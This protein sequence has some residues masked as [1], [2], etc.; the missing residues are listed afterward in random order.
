VLEYTV[1]EAG[2]V[3]VF[4]SNDG[5]EV[6]E[7]YFD[8]FK[9][10][11][12]KS[13]VVSSQDYY[14]FGLAFNSYSRENS[15]ANQ[16]KFQG[17]EHQDELDLGWDSFKWRN[18]QPDI[19]RFFNVDP[20]AEKYVYN[21]P[22]AFSENRVVNSIELEGLEKVIVTS[23]E[24]VAHQ[25]GKTVNTGGELVTNKNVYNKNFNEAPNG[26]DYK[27]LSTTMET[28]D[29][30]FSKPKLYEGGDTDLEEM[31]DAVVSGDL[32]NFSHSLTGKDTKEG[33]TLQGSIEDAQFT[34]EIKIDGDNMTFN[35]TLSGGDSDKAYSIKINGGDGTSAGFSI[36]ELKAGRGKDGKS[37]SSI[38]IPFTMDNKGNA[39]FDAQK[40]LDQ[41]KRD[42]SNSTKK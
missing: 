39:V 2:Y 27:K 7:V 38:S 20:L 15:L 25:N 22:Y 24:F 13:P 40:W 6:R 10:E 33:S 36:G 17:Q 32:D 37:N 3:Y 31:F 4:L 30:T 9:V 11:H 5:E 1:K 19:G 29:G 26:G 14:P 8:D 18:H 28:S 16:Y 35:T 41:V 12:V 21:S 34:V 23:S 42:E